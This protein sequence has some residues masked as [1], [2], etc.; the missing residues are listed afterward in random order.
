MTRNPKKPSPDLTQKANE[1][2]TY[3]DQLMY[4]YVVVESKSLD[5]PQGTLTHQEDKVVRILGLQGPRIMREI[6][7]PLGLASSTATCIIDRLVNKNLVL[8]ER[9]EKDRRIVKVKL[10]KAGKHICQKRRSGFIKLCRNMLNRL[11]PE[12]QTIYLSL[13]RKITDGERTKN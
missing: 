1:L 5:T 13:T 9:S 6:A 3:L 11:T 10:T 2:F 12:E 4:R 7:A 8:R